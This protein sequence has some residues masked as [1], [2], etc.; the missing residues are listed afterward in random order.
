MLSFIESLLLTRL[1][2][3]ARFAVT[4]RLPSLLERLPQDQSGL[5]TLGDSLIAPPHVLFHVLVE[6]HE[7]LGA[8]D[9]HV[10][11]PRNGCPE[12]VTA[13]VV[14]HR[15]TPDRKSTRLNSS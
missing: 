14:V 9:R 3:R 6:R 11:G 8:E 10:H 5:G 13:H 2:K 1:V 12:H 15:N 4:A 7:V